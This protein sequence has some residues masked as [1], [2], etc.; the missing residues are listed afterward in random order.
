[1]N[2]L[3]ALPLCIVMLL[4]FN[5]NASIILSA[6]PNVSNAISGDSISVELIVSNLDAGGPDS[7]GGF[8]MDIS[9]DSAVMSV[10]GYAFGDQ[11]GNIDLGEALD[12]SFG[13]DAL[14]TVNL[15]LLSLLFD[16]E[17]DSLQPSTFVLATID[18]S[19]DSLVQG[20]ATEVS[21]DFTLFSDAF[22]FELT[23][24]SI[25]GATISNNPIVDINSPALFGLFT[26]AIT[27]IWARRFR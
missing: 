21:Y 17:L 16:F 11:L 9:Y 20:S 1:M 22:G 4:A 24:S 23:A 10:T 5:A 19:V 13:D 27:I 12:F 3:K 7:L 8:E 14:G 26:L 15:S 6:V 18:F 2:I 25:T